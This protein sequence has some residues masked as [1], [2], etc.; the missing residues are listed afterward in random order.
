MTV[1]LFAKNAAFTLGIQKNKAFP[2]TKK[3]SESVSL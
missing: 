1:F 3:E 2:K